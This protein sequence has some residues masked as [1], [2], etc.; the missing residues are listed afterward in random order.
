MIP[1]NCY[2]LRKRKEKT[3]GALDTPS[4]VWSS[5][6]RQSL[7]RRDA[8]FEANPRASKL[9]PAPASN[10][11]TPK[12]QRTPFFYFVE[13]CTAVPEYHIPQYALVDRV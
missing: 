2:M 9:L 10:K 5:K 7:G 13:H 12:P 4:V 8:C 11:D 6:T 3:I 1:N